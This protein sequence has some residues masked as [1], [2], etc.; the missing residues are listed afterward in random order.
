[1]KTCDNCIWK[2]HGKNTWCYYENNKPTKNICREH[3]YE[4]DNHDCHMSAEF[5]FKG[6]KLCER[7]SFLELGIAIR[8]VRQ[9]YSEDYECFLGDDDNNE[10]EEIIEK[11]CKYEGIEYK[12]V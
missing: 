6:K 8:T 4:C 5:E 9:Y 12:G 11:A 7:C 3:D 1:M 2:F 10:A